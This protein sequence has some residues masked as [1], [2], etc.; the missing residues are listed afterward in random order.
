MDAHETTLYSSVLIAGL[1]ML[2]LTLY[3]AFSAIWHQ[4]KHIRLQRQNFLDEIGLLE[5]ER[6]R[7][8]RDLHDELAPM[9]SIARFQLACFTGKDAA[10]RE[11]L[12]KA[13]EAL[14]RVML[15]L[16]EIAVNLNAN[17]LVKKGF[18]FALADF[19]LELE[20]VSPLKIRF[21]YEVVRDIPLE[22]G[23]H[24]YR[25]V[26]EVAHNA[27]KHS[28]ARLLDVQ[29]KEQAG[30]LLLYLGDDGKGFC[31]EQCLKDSAGIGLQSIR[32]RTGMLGGTFECLSGPTK[33]TS[34][35]F[36]IPFPSKI[37][38]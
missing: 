7:I 12:Q 32:S 3:F 28:A 31:Y 15:R 13:S 26:Q 14:E 25:I 19:F 38:L 18:R 6:T 20:C 29:V 2:C 1:G 24:L 8:A 16:G 17:V 5:K 11:A 4:R 21:H 36:A 27:F 33:G 22:T 30:K 10:E 34:Y 37:N 35:F 23:I 9:L